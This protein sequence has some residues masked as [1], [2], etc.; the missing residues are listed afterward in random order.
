MVDLEQQ[1]HVAQTQFAGDSHDPALLHR[2]CELLTALRRE[3]DMLPWADRALALDPHDPVFIAR[4]ADALYLLG[5]YLEAADTWKR[6]PSRHD[7]PELYRL[8]LGMSLMMA[9]DLAQA[10]RLLDEAYRMAES[11]HAEMAASI[12]FALGEAML[13]A[14]DPRG[15]AYW[16]MRDDVPRLSAN[17]RP[18]GLPT[19]DGESDVSGK[20]VL[21]THEHGFGD[22]FLLAACLA[23]WLDAGAHAMLTCHP[24]NHALMQASLP[25]CEVVAAPNPPQFHAP[26]PR[27]L[28]SRV[29]GFAPDLHATL[30]HLPMLKARQT[31][32]PEQ[33][34]TPYIEVPPQKQRIAAE[35]AAQLRNQHPGKK[36]IGLFWDCVQRH[37]PEKGAIVRCWASRRSLPLD[38]VNEIVAHPAMAECMHFV[39]LHHPAAAA[40]AGAPAC[41]VGHYQPVIRD[42]ADTAACIAQL[43]AVVAV[44]SGVAN[45][46]A[47]MGMRTCVPTHICGDW[48]WG[49]EGTASP[50][51][52]HATALRQTREGD[53]SDVVRNIHAWLMRAVA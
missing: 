42:F 35:W 10:I 14:G 39:N 40:L 6:D 45:L 50:W 49:V 32:A 41:N 3:E 30:L 34:F 22:N 7:R 17:Y 27:E 29:D 5:R 19:W 16:R 2:I 13:K 51:I 24:Q 33:W 1:L 12:G 47:M 25:R 52:R 15:F 11:G 4:R 43:D 26:L 37:W 44:D 46:T 36:L 18:S 20:R 9:G 31:H 38:A 48:R 8:R 21:V 23:D 28:Q 53:W